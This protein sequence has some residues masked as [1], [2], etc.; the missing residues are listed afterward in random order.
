MLK[1]RC[2]TST[3]RKQTA[4]LSDPP[5]TETPSVAHALSLHQRGQLK[6]ALVEITALLAAD[7]AVAGGHNLHVLILAGLG[8]ATGAVAAYGRALAEAP[9]D[10]NAL[11]NRGSTLMQLGR[12]EEAMA[13]LRAAVAA[14]PASVTAH[15]NLGRAYSMQS[16]NDR[17]VACYDQVLAL[18]PGNAKALWAKG[19]AQLAGG[20]FAGGWK[21]YNARWRAPGFGNGAPRDFGKP[22]YT[23]AETLAGRTLFVHAEQGFGD[24]IQFCRYIA[25]V[26]AMGAKVLFMVQTELRDLLQTSALR[27]TFF[28][29]GVQMPRFDYDIPL[30]NLPAALGT[31]IDTI[32][33]Q[34][35]YLAAPLAKADSEPSS[36]FMSNGSA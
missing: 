29:P 8:D 15:F 7:P 36:P 6:E 10:P 13:D 17:A 4:L 24:T 23:G 16:D 30:L 3:A 11:T 34:V 35:P 25:P 1:S 27:C 31:T 33:A 20:D 21:N 26:A 5:A 28:V 32:P 18:E 9:A 22:R 2:E 19:V 14:D 12:H